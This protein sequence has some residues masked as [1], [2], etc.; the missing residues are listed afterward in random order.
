MS[1]VL[2]L[3]RD[4]QDLRPQARGAEVVVGVAARARIGRELV[5]NSVRAATGRPLLNWNVCVQ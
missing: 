2:V 3:V 5:G 4:A 1:V